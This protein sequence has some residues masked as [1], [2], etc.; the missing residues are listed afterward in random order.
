VTEG[1]RQRWKLLERM[2]DWKKE[3]EV[4]IENEEERNGEK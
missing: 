4:E 3:R 2:K 1:R